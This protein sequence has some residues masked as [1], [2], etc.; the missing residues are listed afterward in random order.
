MGVKIQVK[1]TST[2]S[3]L[4]L[5]CYFCFVELFSIALCNHFA[6]KLSRVGNAEIEKAIFC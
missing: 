6:V 5:S 2:C 1:P 4:N 3:L